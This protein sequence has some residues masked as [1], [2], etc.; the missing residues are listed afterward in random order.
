MKRYY[1]EYTEFGFKASGYHKNEKE[2]RH[3]FKELYGVEPNEIQV[4]EVV[5]DGTEKSGV[6]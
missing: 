3:A 5:E 2:A 4:E 6:K 1:M